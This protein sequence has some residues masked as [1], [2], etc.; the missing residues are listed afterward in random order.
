MVMLSC[1][2]HVE[3]PTHKVFSSSFKII[4]KKLLG[5][6]LFLFLSVINNSVEFNGI[7][8][9]GVI[10][11]KKKKSIFFVYPN[12]LLLVALPGYKNK[13]ELSGPKD[14]IFHK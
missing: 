1:Y 5:R 6:P 7:R 9:G 12:F 3:Q 11:K 14:R 8:F 10:F 2:I 4:K 13:G